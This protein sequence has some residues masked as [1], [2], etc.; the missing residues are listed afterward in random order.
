MS[1]PSLISRQLILLLVLFWSITSQAQINGKIGLN[2]LPMRTGSPE[3]LIEADLTAKLGLIL[4][5]GI[6]RTDERCCTKE[7]SGV[8]TYRL[9]GGYIRAG[10]IYY[11]WL[12]E[13]RI[14][15]LVQLQY[16][17]SWHNERA[18]Q[19]MMHPDIEPT[20]WPI[21]D[22]SLNG[23]VHGAAVTLGSDIRIHERIGLR[24]GLQYG[25]GIRKRFIGSRTQTYQPGLGRWM[26]PRQFI[27][28][29][30]FRIGK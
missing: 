16:L 1:T 3:L 9:N 6:T 26:Q 5:A 30:W 14:A 19:Y 21:V 4:N 28:A 10:A 22:R 18:L 20:E 13:R 23:V 12:R 17:A 15:P 24:A 11:P 2:F 8:I 25:Y 7:Y 29:L 27:A